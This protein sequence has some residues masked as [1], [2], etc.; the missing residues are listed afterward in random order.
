MSEPVLATTKSAGGNGATPPPTPAPTT[1]YKASLYPTDG[2][3]PEE[4]AKAVLDVERELGIP[5]WLFIHGSNEPFADLD[6]RIV[7][8]FRAARA[9]L[10]EGTGVALL[11]DSPGGQARSAYLIGSLLRRRAGH[12]VALVPN[13]AKSAAT[14]LALGA[15]EIVM[16]EFGELGPLDAQV[17][18]PDREEMGSALNEVA[19]LERLTASA[20]EMVDQQMVFFLLRTS[21]RI[22]T[23]LP[24][25]TRFV[26][27][28]LRP[29]YEKI[30]TVHYTQ[31]SRILKVAE[32]YAVRL[33][34]PYHSIGKAKAIARHLIEHYPAHDYVIDREE[35]AANDLPVVA[36]S[37][38][39]AQA[40]DRIYPFL[41]VDLTVFGRVVEE[42]QP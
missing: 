40:F 28:T 9:D 35:A 6:D 37:P 11:I 31:M 23:L 41:Q 5:V 8:L 20:L 14:L 30:D 13:Y 21:K 36:P 12:Y 34:L 24:H 16:G 19:A 42:A 10:P 27:D 17:A 25:I 39:V 7:E 32:E 1:I 18:D 22:E 2:P 4:F 15:K 29:L 38:A 3:L 26:A 33:L